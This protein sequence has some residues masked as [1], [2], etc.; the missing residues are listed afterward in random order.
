MKLLCFHL[1]FNPSPIEDFTD[2]LVYSDYRSPLID[3][4]TH[5]RNLE[6]ESRWSR[7]M[8]RTGVIL[9]PYLMTTVMNTTLGKTKLFSL[10][11]RPRTLNQSERRSDRYS[12]EVARPKN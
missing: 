7:M 9:V 6:R 11:V 4:M 3:L 10:L 2:A 1:A 8:R 5:F 12:T